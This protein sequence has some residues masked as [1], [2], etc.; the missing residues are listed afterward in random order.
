[1]CVYFDS[2]CIYTQRIVD[3]YSFDS[4]YT[5]FGDGLNLCASMCDFGMNLI[6]LD[7]EKTG[8]NKG[9]I[10]HTKVFRRCRCTCSKRALLH[11]A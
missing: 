10:E 6:V 7:C 1:M 9:L 11:C 4:F 8:L 3:P 5:L 2:V